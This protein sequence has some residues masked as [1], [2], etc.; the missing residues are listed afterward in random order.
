MAESVFL[1]E[2]VSRA[3]G[4]G[5]RPNDLSICAKYRNL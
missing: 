4:G 2:N 5:N 3:G 1:A